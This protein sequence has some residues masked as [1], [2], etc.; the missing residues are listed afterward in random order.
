MEGQHCP[1]AVAEEEDVPWWVVAFGDQDV[2]NV[3]PED[4]GWVVEASRVQV[5]LA[6][7][8][9]DHDVIGPVKGRVVGTREDGRDGIEASQRDAGC[10]REI[11]VST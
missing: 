5:D 3:V 7:L 4:S 10:F 2:E 11:E 6:F 8:L 1:L 9:V